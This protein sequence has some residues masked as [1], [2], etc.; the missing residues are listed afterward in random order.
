LPPSCFSS[1]IANHSQ[2]QESTRKMLL[3]GI[4]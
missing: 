2:L 3:N 4:M 1:V